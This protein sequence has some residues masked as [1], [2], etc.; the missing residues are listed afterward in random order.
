[1]SAVAL[2]FFACLLHV[3]VQSMFMGYVSYYTIS[4]ALHISQ[5][6]E[7]LFRLIC[8][9]LSTRLKRSLKLMDFLIVGGGLL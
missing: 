7:L 5:P 4:R 1:M 8:R 2:A 9:T 6:T 3:Q